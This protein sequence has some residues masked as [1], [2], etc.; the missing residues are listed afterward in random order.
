VSGYG[1]GWRVGVFAFLVLELCVVA[2]VMVAELV[3]EWH[4]I[5]SIPLLLF[6]GVLLGCWVAAIALPAMAAI[7]AVIGTVAGVRHG[8]RRRRLVAA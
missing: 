4:G 2:V 1:Y 8:V 7:G 3:A 6:A 5:T